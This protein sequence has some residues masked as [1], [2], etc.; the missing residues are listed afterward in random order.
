MPCRFALKI[1]LFTIR[2]LSHLTV[3]DVVDRDVDEEEAKEE[4]CEGGDLEGGLRRYFFLLLLG[5]SVDYCFSLKIFRI[6]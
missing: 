3:V 2:V 5:I 4:F 1:A 6:Q